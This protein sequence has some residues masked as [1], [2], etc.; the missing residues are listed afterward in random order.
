MNLSYE[1]MMRILLRLA[2]ESLIKKLKKATECVQSCSQQGFFRARWNPNKTTE[3]I[4]ALRQDLGDA[5]LLSLVHTTLDVSACCSS[6]DSL[7]A[8]CTPL[9]S[10]SIHSFPRAASESGPIKARIHWSIVGLS[11]TGLEQ[12]IYSATISLS[13][14]CSPTRPFGPGIHAFMKY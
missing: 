11:Y 10:P 1:V 2:I 12:Q 4:A 7:H 8:H 9:G 6:Q 14:V 5:F 3:E 13:T